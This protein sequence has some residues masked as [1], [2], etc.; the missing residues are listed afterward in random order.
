MEMKVVSI[1][2]SQSPASRAGSVSKRQVSRWTLPFVMPV[3]MAAA[4]LVTAMSPVTGS[5]SGGWMS[6]LSSASGSVGSI[7]NRP[8]STKSFMDW[9]A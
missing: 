5:P 1:I 7:S 9:D 6:G 2:S 3:W 4:W 8:F